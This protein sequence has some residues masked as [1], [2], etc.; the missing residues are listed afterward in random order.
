[1]RK[2]KAIKRRPCYGEGDWFA[3]PLRDD[4]GYATGLIA[5]GKK[6]KILFGYFFGPAR[7]A[8]PTI[9]QVMD[10]RPDDAV[11]LAMF[12]DL[13]LYEGEW[14]IIGRI[15]PWDR[16]AWPLP[17][18]VRVDSINPAHSEMVVHSDDD[19]DLS[20]IIE[21]TRCDA[22]EM[23]HLPVERLCGSGSIEIQLT[24]LLR[25]VVL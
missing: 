13:G 10:Y 16:A 25:P 11:L 5:R 6:G 1:M 19:L 24:E 22:R 9:E 7:G 20:G 23:T 8:V 21:S 2:R 12:G 18:F 15:E 4:M 17:A 3:I 14:P